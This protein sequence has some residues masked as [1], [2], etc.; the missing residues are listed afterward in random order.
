MFGI[1][2]LVSSCGLF[3]LHLGLTQGTHDKRLDLLDWGNPSGQA[4]DSLWI[5]DVR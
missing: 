3:K 4:G 2:R 5:R 1:L